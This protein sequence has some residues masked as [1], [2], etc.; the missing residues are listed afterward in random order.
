MY[1]WKQ[2]INL[3]KPLIDYA[4][5][6]EKV[7][8]CGKLYE[9]PDRF[10]TVRIPELHAY[11]M[12]FIVVTFNIL[13]WN[14]GLFALSGIGWKVLKLFTNILVFPAALFSMLRI[15]VWPDTEIVDWLTVV[16]ANIA[17]LGPLG[18]YWIGVVL[19]PIGW[20]SSYSPGA[21][22][23]WLWVATVSWAASIF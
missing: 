18:L 1:N 12:T 10:D 6:P 2:E 20:F 11:M 7:E 21:F 13:G 3:I 23:K 19:I 16:F 8:F 4:C 22:Y 5:D 14:A 15:F 17:L 9:Y